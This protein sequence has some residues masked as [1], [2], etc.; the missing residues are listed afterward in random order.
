MNAVIIII[1]IIM[2]EMGINPCFA[3]LSYA[4]DLRI[5]NLEGTLPDTR[6]DEVIARTGKPVV[7][8]L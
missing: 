4:S 3:W 7:S 8:I 5:G 6:C 1:I 2:G